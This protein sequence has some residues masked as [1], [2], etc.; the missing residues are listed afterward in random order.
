MFKKYNLSDSAVIICVIFSLIYISPIVLTN[1]YYTDDMA[2][3]IYGY[4]WDNDGRAIT[5]LLMMAISGGGKILNISPYT[6]IFSSLILSFSGWVLCYVI[7]LCGKERVH[8]AAFL[9]LTSPFML[10]NLTYKYDSLPM[11]ISVLAVILPF[12][13]FNRKIFPII[14]A[15]GICVTM[16]TYQA[17]A[18]IFAMVFSL[19]ITITYLKDGV[20][21]LKK[22]SYIT[23]ATS[24]ISL[25]L[26]R[27]SNYIYP[28]KYSGRNELI[29]NSDNTFDELMKNIGKAIELTAAA[30][31]FHM[32]IAMVLISAFF[33][34]S[35]LRIIKDSNNKIASFLFIFIIILTILSYPL[36]NILLLNPWWTSRVFLGFP[37]AIIAMIAI[38]HV[39]YVKSARYLSV[40]LCA[41]S[42]P[43]MAAYAN[44]TKS[45]SDYSQEITRD[46]FSHIESRDKGIVVNGAMPLSDEVKL[47]MSSYPI[48]K[49]IILPYMNNGWSWGGHFISRMGYIDR[50]NYILGKKREGVIKDICNINIKHSMHNYEIRES[51]DYVLIDFKKTKCL[52][53]K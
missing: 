33:V 41:I 42:L 44:A 43:M 9:I 24:I 39:Y 12:L 15:I 26:L 40:F 20:F 50:G 6:N 31:S 36:I 14:A 21:D 53:T 2:R 45:Q 19:K 5:S 52:P 37:V 48:F 10:E 1:V 22:Y 25:I 46:I 11:S 17:S 27:V 38:I 32:T 16:L 18:I 49:R 23:L 34:L 3:S 8:P 47:S 7:D 28:P 29:F 13:F 4:A 51:R 30:F 35:S